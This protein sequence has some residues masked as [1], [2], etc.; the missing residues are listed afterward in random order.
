MSR[1]STEVQNNGLASNG[2]TLMALPKISILTPSLNMGRYLQH[3]IRGV[4]WQEY[5]NFEHIVIDGG[6]SDETI[7]ILKQYSHLRWVSE[8]DRGLSHALNKGIQM[9][10]GDIVGWCNVDDYYFPG[11]FKVAVKNLQLDPSIMVLYGDYREIDAQGFPIRIRREVDF[12]LFVLKY[13]HVDYI[14]APAAF[15]RKSIHNDGF[16]FKEDLEYAM[17]YDLC[18]RLALAGYRFKHIPVILCDF[19]RHADAKSANPMQAIEH[20]KILRARIPLFQR[21]P[22]VLSESLRFLLLLCAR[23]KRIF[24]RAVRGHY[25]EQRRC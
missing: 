4:L 16:W 6:S 10:T 7:G 21:F 23:T 15:W 3:C 20:E 2:G 18:L 25:F 12:D 17:D 19:R 11:A 9:A 8:P 1:D 5:P 14:P 24:V 13:L 22:P